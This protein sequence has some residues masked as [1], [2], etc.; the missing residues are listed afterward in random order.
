MKIIFQIISDSIRM[1]RKDLLDFSRDRMQLVF[2]IIMPIFMM[3]MTGFIFP[4]ENSL[5]N[6]PLGIANQDTGQLSQ[7]LTQVL[8]DLKTSDN[9]QVFEIKT[10]ADSNAIKDAIKAQ[11][12]NGGLYIAS[13]FSQMIQRGQPAEVSIIP[14]QSNPQIS[15]IL[16]QLLQQVIAGTSTN[17][18]QAKV[19]EIIKLTAIANPQLSQADPAAIIQPIQSTIDNLIPGKPN[20]FQFVAPGIMALIVMMSVMTGLAVSVTREREA[21][22]LDGLLIAPV[23]RLAI[24][25]GK[26]FS[27]TVRGLVQG[28]VVL[29]LAILIF[30]VHVYG[31]WLIMIVLMILGVF[32]F[33]GIGILVSAVASAQESAMTIMMT[34]QFPMMFLSGTFFPI[35][36]MPQ[37]MQYISKAIPLTYEA[38]ALRKVIVLGAGFNAVWTETL[39]LFVFG[40]IMLAIAVPTFRRV[41]TR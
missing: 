22:T 8:T 11:K 2:F 41:I 36:Q 31:N 33:M 28:M 9:N 1:A 26:A 7:T 3:I 32:A 10:Y 25:L 24:I 35:Q 18:A 5:K 38:S 39:I 6:I 23:S 15:Q 17:V 4:T 13:D 40:A 34:F 29:L 19:G 27:Q 12:I 21:G 14:D 20:Y 30:G 16:T 37:V